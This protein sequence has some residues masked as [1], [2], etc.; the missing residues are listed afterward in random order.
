MSIRAVLATLV[1]WH[2]ASAG[3]EV[4]AGEPAAAASASAE[5]IED[6]VR[7]NLPRDSSVQTLVFRSTDRLGATTGFESTLYWKRFE[8]GLSK[9]VLRFE[10]PPDMRGAGVLLIEKRG[11]RPDTF[12]YLP[13]L[14]KV[15]RVSSRSASSSLFGTDFSYEDFERLIGMSA[16]ARR[17]RLADVVV[18]GRI[19]Y[20]IEALPASDAGSAYERVATF[21][22]PETCIPLETRS[23]E[24]GGQLRRRLVVDPDRITR[25]GDRWVPRLQVMHDLRD[26]TRTE[27]H[28]EHIEMEADIHRRMFSE[29]WLESGAH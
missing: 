29:R 10:A 19:L 5:E 14:R 2:A 13:A 8:G 6:C 21:V 1:V 26:E 7:A 18:D 24:P 4:D 27:L 23:F 28:V 25:E 9:V 11:R 15:K 12:M 16:D 17:E 22:D 20:V 3:A